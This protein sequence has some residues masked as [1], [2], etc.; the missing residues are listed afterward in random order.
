MRDC[1]YCAICAIL[2]MANRND[3]LSEDSLATFLQEHN[4][5]L[6]AIL[7]LSGSSSS[8]AVG[9]VG[10]PPVFSTASTA[11]VTDH[12]NTYIEL[13]LSPNKTLANVPLP[14]VK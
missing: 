7:F 11:T 8:L 5:L 12:C 13:I 3:C 9:T 4:R 10:N 14:V 2:F 6:F 1:L